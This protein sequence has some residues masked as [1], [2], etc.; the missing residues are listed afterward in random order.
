MCYVTDGSRTICCYWI[1]DLI[2]VEYS[3]TPLG[4]CPILAHN[5]YFPSPFT[6]F[7]WVFSFLFYLSIE[8]PRKG[9]QRE[10]RSIRQ[11]YAVNL[12][13][14]QWEIANLRYL[15]L[16][17]PVSFTVGLKEDSSEWGENRNL[18]FT[19]ISSFSRYFWTETGR[20]RPI[21]EEIWE[22]A[23]AHAGGAVCGLHPTARP[24][25]GGPLPTA[26][27]GQPCQGASGCI[28]LWREARLWQV[29]QTGHHPSRDIQ[30]GQRVE[31]L[32]T[33]QIWGE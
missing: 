20:H 10:T 23:G 14:Y 29:H 6:K 21:R 22:P 19:S 16:F 11:V 17:Q 13:V 33:W 12:A 30:T 15:W 5:I 2:A 31:C 27:P 4:T 3:P 26:R 24:E 18:G 8:Y 1:P 9:W 7:I 25:G 32:V 28:R